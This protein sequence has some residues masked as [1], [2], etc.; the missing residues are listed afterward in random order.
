MAASAA[1]ARS[2]SPAGNKSRE[3]SRS[4]EKAARQHKGVTIVEDKERQQQSYRD[5][6]KKL[7]RRFRD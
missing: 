4:P 5:A 1:R 7:D 2:I 3:G 6:E